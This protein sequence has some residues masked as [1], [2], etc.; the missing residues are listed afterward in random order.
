M[1]DPKPTLDLAAIQQRVRS[2]LSSYTPQ[3]LLITDNRVVHD[4]SDAFVEVA[5][6]A[7]LHLIDTRVPNARE[8]WMAQ[9]A[10]VFDLYHGKTPRAPKGEA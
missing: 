9:A 8:R 6:V 4:K 1:P 7:I 5:M 10:F 3:R 2:A